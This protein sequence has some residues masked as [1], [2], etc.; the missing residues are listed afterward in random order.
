MSDRTASWRSTFSELAR[1]FPL[2]PF[3]LM[4]ALCA[5]SFLIGEQFPVTR[6]PMYDK[7]PDHTFYV[8]VADRDGHPIPVHEI[9]GINTSKL[10]KPYD[11][12]L[13]RTRK[14]LGKRKKELTADER[15]VAGETALR[16][17]YE[18]APAAGKAKLEAFAPIQL[19]HV[20]IFSED[21]K[22]AEQ[23]AE[24]VASFTPGGGAGG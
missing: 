6:F 12:E 21:G 17:L 24:K 19:L 2:W 18:S 1:G 20:W 16:K 5:S 23:A 14:K 9:T 8:Y 10:K 7:F 15:R 13:N 3:V 11:K 22:S 4:L